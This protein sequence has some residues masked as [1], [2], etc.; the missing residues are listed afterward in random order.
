[1][2]TSTKHFGLVVGP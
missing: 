2:K 1:M